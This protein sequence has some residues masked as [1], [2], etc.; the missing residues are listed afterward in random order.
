M[1]LLQATVE[2][3]PPLS[4]FVVVLIQSFVL[5]LVVF[6]HVGTIRDEKRALR[7]KKEEDM[8]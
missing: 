4:L 2:T 6:N 5:G 1:A 8:K 7:E 3:N